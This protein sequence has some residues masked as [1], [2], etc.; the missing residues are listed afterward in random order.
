MVAGVAEGEALVTKH[1]ISGFGGIDSKTGIITELRHE[2]RGQ[3]FKDKVSSSVSAATK[4]KNAASFIETHLDSM[5]TK[6]QTLLGSG[7]AED[8]ATAATE[9]DELYSNINSRA[10]GANQLVNH[11]NINLIGNTNP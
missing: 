10:D 8:R 3:S 1:T 6:L 9:F 2:L 7:S 5:K 4:A 11:Q